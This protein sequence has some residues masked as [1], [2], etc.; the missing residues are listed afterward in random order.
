MVRTPA[1][2][3]AATQVSSGLILGLSAVIYAISY[4][5]LMF[6]GKLAVLVPH[7]ITVTLITAALGALY[8]LFSE[9]PTLVS[10]P[11]ANTSSVL[12]GMLVAATAIDLPGDDLL[13]RALVLLLLASLTAAFSYLLIER[14]GLSRL[15]R[16]IPFQ[17][18]AGF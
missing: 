6:P 1:L 9:D 12:A 4:A 17:V 8:G 5:A 3:D 16:F 7:A 10:G 11:E 15:V 13:N 14:F 2:A 18:M